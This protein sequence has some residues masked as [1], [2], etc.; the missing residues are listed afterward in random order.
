MIEA[1]TCRHIVTLNKINIHNTSSVLTCE[2]LLL[3]CKR[4]VLLKWKA[5]NGLSKCFLNLLYARQ[6]LTIT[7]ATVT[8][9]PELEVCH[10]QPM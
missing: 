1:E 2:S 10:P 7:T 4:Y 6:P 3:T 5:R 9:T 8:L